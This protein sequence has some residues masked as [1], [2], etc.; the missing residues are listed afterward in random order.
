MY[1]LNKMA[2]TT[3]LRQQKDCNDACASIKTCLSSFLTWMKIFGLYHEILGDHDVKSDNMKAWSEIT[4]NHPSV[5]P[6]L[7]AVKDQGDVDPREPRTYQSFRKNMFSFGSEPVTRLVQ[8]LNMKLPKCHRLMWRFYSCLVNLF[9]LVTAVKIFLTIL[10]SDAS[11]YTSTTYRILMIFYFS[12]ASLIA[13]S[14]LLSSWRRNYFSL[15]F[16]QWV[17]L[18][19]DPSLKQLGLTPVNCR[20]SVKVITGVTV[21]TLLCVM[22]SFT[23]VG[24]FTESTMAVDLRVVVCYPLPVNGWCLLLLALEYMYSLPV[25]VLPLGFTVCVSF[26]ITKH[27]RKL[28]EALR[29]KIAES[30]G[31]I[32]ARLTDLRMCHLRMC[33]ALKSLNRSLRLYLGIIIVFFAAISIFQLYN[34]VSISVTC[35]DF[36]YSIIPFFSFATSFLVTAISVCILHEAVSVSKCILHET[37]SIYK[38]YD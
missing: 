5:E 16:Q 19:S 37:V 2:P 17:E 30:N 21:T 12:Q 22:V 3:R 9:L 14:P 31:R 15:F 6:S 4:T 36:I 20:T 8:Y 18:S 29:S 10:I 24:L 38:I 35:T 25:T 23:Y 26:L 13:G 7:V 33:K 28:T 11:I 34:I 1:R 27:F 32:P